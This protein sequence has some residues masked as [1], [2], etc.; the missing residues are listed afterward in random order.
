MLQAAGLA[1]GQGY[2]FFY[3]QSGIALNPLTRT[4]VVA[5]KWRVKHYPFSDIRSWAASKVDAGQPHMTAFGG[6]SGAL[7]N[8]G[9]AMLAKA[10]ADAASGFF[11]TVKDI[12]DPKWHVQ[13]IKERDQARWMEIFRQE[14]NEKP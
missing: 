1:D 6:V 5:S 3:G 11:V 7:Q 2:A 14:I 13:M 4:V 12:D 9:N 8:T 10:K